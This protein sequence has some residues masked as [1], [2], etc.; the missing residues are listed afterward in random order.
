MI[1][2][3]V[4]CFSVPLKGWRGEKRSFKERVW[5]WQ[6][7]GVVGMRSARLAVVYR[8]FD[9]S[10]YALSK[11]SFV[12]VFSVFFIKATTPR[13]RPPPRDVHLN[14][15]CSGRTFFLLPASLLPPLTTC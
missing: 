14:F 12:R 1:C 6:A 8:T 13:Y 2:L 4:L 9:R 3:L 10:L 15:L 7:Q 11:V 5:L